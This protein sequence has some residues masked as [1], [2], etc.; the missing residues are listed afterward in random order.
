MIT[1]LNNR[2]VQHSQKQGQKG[3]R[4]R[5]KSESQS[6][7]QRSNKN[8]A[9]R[10]ELHEGSLFKQEKRPRPSKFSSTDVQKA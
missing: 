6:R 1:K 3:R 7:L 5:E 10:I 4:V 9:G 8:C 2:A